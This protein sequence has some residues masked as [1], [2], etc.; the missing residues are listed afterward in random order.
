MHV[1]GVFCL[2]R[3]EVRACLLPDLPRWMDE[4]RQDRLLS[5]DR[6]SPDRD[7]RRCVSGVL[8]CQI[9]RGANQGESHA[10]A[11][12]NGGTQRNQLHRLQGR[13]GGSDGTGFT[14]TT[15]GRDDDDGDG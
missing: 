9:A 4:R 3:F 6:F 14:I 1:I 12:P 5:V 10:P 13:K 2:P 7:F 8:V 15:Q 11:W